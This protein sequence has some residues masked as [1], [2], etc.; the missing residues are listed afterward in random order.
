MPTDRTDILLDENYD[1]LEDG[2]QWAEGPADQQHVE[3]LLL[4]DKGE[5]RQF[6]FFG[7][8]I[9]RRLRQRYNAQS[10]L[11][12]MEVELENDGYTNPEITL[13]KTIKDFSIIV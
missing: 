4:T 11:R 3:L 9:E 12:G 8:G 13:G 2:N 10:F 7:F 1:L 5:A 6:P